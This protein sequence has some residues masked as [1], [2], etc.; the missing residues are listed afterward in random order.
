MTTN[1][2]NAGGG[3]DGLR[4]LKDELEITRQADEKDPSI[5]VDGMRRPPHFAAP[6]GSGA[7]AQPPAP[8]APEYTNNQSMGGPWLSLALV[9][10]IAGLSLTLFFVLRT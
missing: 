2:S 3:L 5:T 8:L 9:A 1:V 10:L 4:A 6:K 7:M